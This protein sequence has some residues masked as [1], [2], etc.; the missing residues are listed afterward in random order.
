MNSFQ[1][2]VVSVD[3]SA[4]CWVKVVSSLTAV[5][6]NIKTVWAVEFGDE[7]KEVSFVVGVH[8]EVRPCG[9]LYEESEIIGFGKLSGVAACVGSGQWILKEGSLEIFFCLHK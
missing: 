1:S 6:N 3:L 4:V 2:A 8:S 9:N 7:V 5:S